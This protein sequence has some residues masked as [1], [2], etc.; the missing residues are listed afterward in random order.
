MVDYT[1]GDSLSP[2]SHWEAISAEGSKELC[3]MLNKIKVPHK[4]M[5]ITT[6]GSRHIAYIVFSKKPRIKKVNRR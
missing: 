2:Y 5:F 4:V 6:Q 1:P 3:E